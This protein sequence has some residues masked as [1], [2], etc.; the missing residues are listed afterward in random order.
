MSRTSLVTIL[1]SLRALARAKRSYGDVRAKGLG[2][3][4]KKDQKDIQVTLSQ[5]PKGLMDIWTEDAVLYSGSTPA[6]GRG[7]RG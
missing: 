7:H 4:S 6:V 1:C 3:L 5:D 2:S